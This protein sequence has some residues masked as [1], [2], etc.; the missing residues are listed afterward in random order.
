MPLSNLDPVTSQMDEEDIVLKPMWDTS[1]S[2]S[3]DCLN[4]TFPLDEAI[5]EIMNGSNRPWD[6]MHHQCYFLR[7]IVESSKKILDLL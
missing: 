6:D 1:S 5:I 7:K 2:C 4:E 3:C